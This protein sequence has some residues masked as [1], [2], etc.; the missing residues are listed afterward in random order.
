MNELGHFRDLALFLDTLNSLINEHARLAFLEIC[1]FHTTNEK[2]SLS[3]RL[4]WSAR[5]LGSE[6][7]Y[8]FER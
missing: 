5:L 4:F 3:T 7:Y 2:S 1:I 6:E 8:L